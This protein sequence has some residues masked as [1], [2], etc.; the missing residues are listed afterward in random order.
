MIAFVTT[1]IETCGMSHPD[2]GRPC[3][4]PAHLMRHPREHRTA[5]DDTW[6]VRRWI[7]CGSGPGWLEPY[8]PYGAQ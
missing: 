5:D 6:P 7:D 3:V 4:E 1:V 2:T 8:E